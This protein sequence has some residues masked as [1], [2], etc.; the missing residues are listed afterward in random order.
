[1]DKQ[2][3]EKLHGFYFEEI[4][5]GQEASISKTITESDIISFANITGDNNPVHISHSFAKKTIFKKVVSHGC[6]L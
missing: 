4:E 6:L 2:D 3:Y 5:V 1:M